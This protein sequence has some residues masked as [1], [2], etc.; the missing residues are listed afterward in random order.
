MGIFDKLSGKKKARA[1]KIEKAPEKKQL[2]GPVLVGT[3]VLEPGPWREWT[4]KPP[5]VY[6][7][8]NLMFWSLRIL[9][10]EDM[11]IDRVGRHIYVCSDVLKPICR[12]DFDGNPDGLLRLPWP[13]VLRISHDGKLL[14]SSGSWLYRVDPE[15]QVISAVKNPGGFDVF[16]DGTIVGVSSYENLNGVCETILRFVRGEKVHEVDV[17][18]IMIRGHMLRC[19]P[20]GFLYVVGAPPHTNWVANTV[21]KFDPAG[22]LVNSCSI[23]RQIGA[24]RLTRDGGIY[25]LELDGDRLVRLSREMK[26]VYDSQRDLRPEA[27]MFRVRK[28][29]LLLLWNAHAIDTDDA[30]NCFVLAHNELMRFKRFWA[31]P[32]GQEARVYGDDKGKLLKAKRDVEELIKVQKNDTLKCKNCGFVNK[33]GSNFCEN[34]GSRLS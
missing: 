30:G 34:C 25:V 23:F 4:P 10:G 1:Q 24:I 26:I 11:V 9:G 28:D 21:F 5:A 18:K 17:S 22:N 27:L 8:R 19:S 15:G 6:K 3:N 13:V 16:P 2:E 32:S 14:V 33:E 12:L 29:G 31:E 7:L 20:D